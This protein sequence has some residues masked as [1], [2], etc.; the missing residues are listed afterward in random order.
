VRYV[1]TFT[2]QASGLPIPLRGGAKL[3]VVV[4]APAT[5]ASGAPSYTP[6]NRAEVVPV[7]GWTT[8]RQ[9]RWD[10]SFEGYTSLGLGVRARLPFRVLTLTDGTTSRVVIDVA[11]RW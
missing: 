8:F 10:S 2:G 11:H 1:S 6:R 9:V 4:N 7:A 3:S 5:T